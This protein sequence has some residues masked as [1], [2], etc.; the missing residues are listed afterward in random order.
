MPQTATHWIIDGKP[1]EE[2]PRAALRHSTL[3]DLLFLTFATEEVD[4]R[5]LMFLDTD[6][7]SEAGQNPE[8]IT[9]TS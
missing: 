4:G 3:T 5:P 1:G 9:S 2:R 6:Q 7:G 8:G